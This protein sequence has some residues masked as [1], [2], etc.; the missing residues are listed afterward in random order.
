ME[1]FW[2]VFNA[3]FARKLRKWKLSCRVFL[4]T[5]SKL[6]YKKSI[7]P[8]YHSFNL[9]AILAKNWGKDNFFTVPYSHQKKIQLILEPFQFFL[10]DYTKSLHIHTKS[11]CTFCVYF[12]FIGELPKV[13]WPNILIIINCLFFRLF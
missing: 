11:V 13:T 10:Y 3:W 5:F 1:M 9:I 4:F 7:N 6:P 12:F 2:I 8:Y